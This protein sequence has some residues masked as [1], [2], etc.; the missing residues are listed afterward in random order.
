MSFRPSIVLACSLT[1][2]SIAPRQAYAQTPPQPDVWLASL[3][4]SGLKV[5]IGSARN[6]TA[7][8]GYDNQPSFS[9]DGRTL[10]YTSTRD[11]AQADIYRFDVKTARTARVTATAPE[12]EYSATVMP[13]GDAISV[14][15]VER[16][17]TQ[18]LWRVPLDGSES[19]VI[20]A[21]IKPVGYHAWADEHTLALFVLGNPATLQL[22]DTRTGKGDTVAVNI[23]RSLHRIPGTHDISFVSKARPDGAWV[24]ALNVKT[25][26]TRQL[27]L[28][29][30]GT[31][32]YA[33]LADGRLIA[34]DGSTLVV[35]D[36]HGPSAWRVVA[37][38]ASAGATGITRLAVSPK[39]DRIAFVAIPK[40]P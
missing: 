27:A 23:G 3:S 30:K 13:S 28:L 34:G 6:I 17:S 14:I 26:Q 33:W 15:R 2:G 38:F 40:A 36:P 9:L 12:S 22:A 39:S 4:V 25:R 37:D 7:R 31:E 8:P 11:D 21:G 20:L 29:P 16:D 35:Y 24:M 32:D 5:V 10:F 1:L 19:T 18:R